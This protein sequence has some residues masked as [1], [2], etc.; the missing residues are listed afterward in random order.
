VKSNIRITRYEQILRESLVLS[1]V[2]H[3][4]HSRLHDGV[5]PEGQSAGRLLKIETEPRFKPL[6]V[7]IDY[8]DQRDRHATNER[9][10][11]RQLVEAFLRFGIK[12]FIRAQR[13]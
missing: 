5:R 11:L 8:T 10:H 6:P 3:D 1:C 13:A 12:N 2:R 4:K 7:G 9:G